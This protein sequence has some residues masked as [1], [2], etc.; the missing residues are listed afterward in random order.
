MK[1]TRIGRLAAIGVL[2]V[3][4]A[5]MCSAHAYDFARAYEAFQAGRFDQAL[6][7]WRPLADAGDAKA[8]YNLG[9]MYADGRGVRR[10]DARALAWWKRAGAQGHVRALHNIGLAYIGNGKQDYTEALRYLRQAAE[11]GFANSQY[12]LG[13]MFHYGLGVE[14][15]AAQ[16][17]VQFRLAAQ[18]G[19]VKAAYNL[20]KAYRD[21]DGVDADD[22]QS[23]HWFR[24]AAE[25]GYAKAQ[26]H[27]ARRLGRGQGVTKDEVEAL[28]W[29]ILSSQQGVADAAVL[30]DFLMESLSPADVAQAESMADRFKAEAR[31]SAW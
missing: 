8:Q 27:L 1:L 5:W 12:S 4:S 23:A 10:D 3:S 16:A 9:V 26:R 7:L 17:A 19:F 15:D 28:K 20:G 31:N 13:K 14:E 25:G 2:A 11:R 21:G 18:Q 30:R 22:A 6:A 24:V 29:A